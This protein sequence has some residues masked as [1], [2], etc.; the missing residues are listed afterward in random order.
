DGTYGR[1]TG[2]GNSA[3]I[4]FHISRRSPA[5]GGDIRALNVNTGV[6]S[7]TVTVNDTLAAGSTFTTTL[8]TGSGQIADTVQVF[9]TST[10]NP[11]VIQ[12][13]GGGDSVNVGQSAS[14]SGDRLANIK[15]T[16]TVLDTGH[17]TRLTVDG[18]GTNSPRTVTLD[19]IVVGR[20]LFGGVSFASGPARVLFGSSSTSGVSDVSNLEVDTG[21]GGDTVNMGLLPAG[22]QTTIDTGAGADTIHLQAAYGAGTRIHG[23]TGS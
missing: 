12:G 22:V 20:S 9:G 6:G 21:G 8:D 13:H 3:D 7:D 19:E 1:A 11:L 18:R 23:G 17:A 16:V 2:L 15:A 10:N 4:L 14:V 5:T